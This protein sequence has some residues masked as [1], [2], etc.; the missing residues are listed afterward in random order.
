MLTLHT[1]IVKPHTWKL[2][3]TPTAAF[4][5]L[6]A[7]AE[8]PAPPPR[9][10]GGGGRIAFEAASLGE[11]FGVMPSPL[12]AAALAL[13]LGEGW[14]PPPR[15]LFPASGFRGEGAPGENSDDIQS[16]GNPADVSRPEAIRSP[17]GELRANMVCCISLRLVVR[18]GSS[19]I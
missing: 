3:M 18:G 12:T 17:P 4:E 16:P 10:E 6:G 7:T 5:G 15:A 2:L 9:V 14:I 19:E 8:T 13:L 1:M 11:G